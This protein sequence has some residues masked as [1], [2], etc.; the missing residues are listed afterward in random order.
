MNFGDINIDRLNKNEQNYLNKEGYWSEDEIAKREFVTNTS[1]SDGYNEME[2]RIPIRENEI[3]IPKWNLV[4]SSWIDIA[5]IF[6]KK[7][8]LQSYLNYLISYAIDDFENGKSMFYYFE[9]NAVFNF[10]YSYL[11]HV[12]D[13]WGYDVL[14]IEKFKWMTFTRFFTVSGNGYLNLSNFF[15]VQSILRDIWGIIGSNFSTPGYASKVKNFY[16]PVIVKDKNG[17]ELFFRAV[18]FL[19]SG[20]MTYCERDLVLKLFSIRDKLELE[21]VIFGK[22]ALSHTQENAKCRQFFMYNI[23]A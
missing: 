3:F 2:I 16:N 7:E 15:F 11:I 10:D 9:K 5:L 22:S 12:M 20:I 14:H 4:V 19:S 6:G 13:E 8:L 17:E 1:S 18:P 23:G 21:Q